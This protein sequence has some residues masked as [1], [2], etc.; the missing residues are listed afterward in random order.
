MYNIQQN[1]FHT[2]YRYSLGLSHFP[3][4]DKHI[5]FLEHNPFRTGVIIIYQF[6][7]QFDLY[8]FFCE[9]TK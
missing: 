7:N 5:I 4:A 9:E 6:Y 8:P 1:L 2:H 3:W